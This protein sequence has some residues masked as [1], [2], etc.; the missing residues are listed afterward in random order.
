MLNKKH[1]I[2]IHF[3]TVFVQGSRYLCSFLVNENSFIS[4]QDTNFIKSRER[5]QKG[6]EV[7]AQ[8]Q[9]KKLDLEH[10]KIE[11]DKGVVADKWVLFPD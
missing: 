6:F 1:Y 2:V 9:R 5:N 8:R 4:G 3:Y 7:T 10:Y 11:A